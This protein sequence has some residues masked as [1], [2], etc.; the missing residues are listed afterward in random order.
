MG[1]RNTTKAWENAY[2]VRSKPYILNDYEQR[3][4][5]CWLKVPILGL[6]QKYDY[7]GMEV[8]YTSDM[9]LKHSQKGR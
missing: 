9:V 8:R 2:V 1:V 7:F 3:K 5:K 6:R 4:R